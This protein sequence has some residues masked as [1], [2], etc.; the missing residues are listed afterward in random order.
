MA[1]KHND[2]PFVDDDADKSQ[3]PPEILPTFGNDRFPFT[4]PKS[5]VEEGS[6]SK[7][8]LLARERI[9]ECSGISPD[10]VPAGL[11]RLIEAADGW[12]EENQKSLAQGRTRSIWTDFGEIR[13]VEFFAAP[14]VLTNDPNNGRVIEEARAKGQRY[15]E[16][17]RDEEVTGAP[18]IA[19]KD[20]HEFIKYVEEAAAELG[21]MGAVKDAKNLEDLVSVGLQGVLEPGLTTPT[22][23]EDANRD[24]TWILKQDD[25][26]RRLAMQRFCLRLAT[27]QAINELEAWDDHLREP[28]GNLVLRHWSAQ[29]VADARQKASHKG[30]KY[31]RPQSGAEE[32]VEAWCAR[33]TIIQRTVVRNSIMP[34]RLVIGYRNLATS[35][36]VKSS[37]FEV[38]Q[39]F[40]RRTHI[41]EAAQLEWSSATQATNVALDACRRIRARY[42]AAGYTMALAPHEL[43]AVYENDRVEWLAVEPDDSRH[44]LRMAGK[45]IATMVCTDTTAEYDVKAS[46]TAYSMST[47]HTKVRENRA[48]VA[49][50]L[51]MPVLGITEK[52]KGDYSRARAT[53][54]RAS[55]HPMFVAVNR[56]GNGVT[57]PWWGHLNRP[58]AE[59]EAMADAEFDAGL[60]VDDQPD[61]KSVGGYGP[62]TR[63]LL[64]LAILGQATNPAVRKP[65][66]GE[67]ATPWQLTLNGLGGTRGDTLTTP[68]L[69]MRQVLAQRKKD[70]VHQLAEIVR[71]AL[72]GEVPKNTLDPDYEEKVGDKVVTNGTL[73]E[74]FLR[75][76]ALGWAKGG[77]G[78]PTPAPPV[79]DPYD[80]ALK[81]LGDSVSSAAANIAP[82]HE[83]GKVRDRYLAT[84]LPDEYANGVIE[85]VKRVLSV[86]ERG[87]IIAEMQ[88]TGVSGDEDEEVDQ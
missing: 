38:V 45:T 11:L 26:N 70:G 82:F 57:D 50:S 19:V 20:A 39:R 87:Q 14:G 72:S 43:D 63:A 42:D 84:G 7:T 18:V 47:H 77:G 40:V 37:A 60:G 6:L 78:S 16:P 56:H 64:F 48:K 71:A 34:T 86:L 81:A 61:D 24:A 74:R 79:G 4:I 13:Y 83:A 88:S 9:A 27:G 10:S 49:V 52:D 15:L 31:W 58:V 29:D 65:L 53:V 3:Y 54:D 68:D 17:V 55:R 59:L 44:P 32:A 73:T 51:A 41:K 35:P 22:L 85:Q 46:L 23:I 21:F 69:V 36:T 66:P 80:R 33:A 2:Y 25:G 30:A 62:A 75:G 12:P 1:V 5:R 8:A 67:A 28:G 76:P